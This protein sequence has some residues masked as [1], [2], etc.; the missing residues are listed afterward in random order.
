[1]DGQGPT[2]N[3][4]PNATLGM[5]T[6]LLPFQNPD[7]ALEYYTSKDL[8]DIEAIGYTYGHS[9]MDQ[10]VPDEDATS[11]AV[12]T[13]TATGPAPKIL[14]VAGM[15]RADREGSFMI[16]VF[17]DDQLVGYES[18]LSRGN[19]KGCANCLKTLQV[20]GRFE[21]PEIEEDRSASVRVQIDDRENMQTGEYEFFNGDVVTG[22][23]TTNGFTPD[24][25]LIPEAGG[26]TMKRKAP[27][28]NIMGDE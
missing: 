24:Y 7:N 3:L 16:K 27:S 17:V 5:D 15:S 4:S 6:P 25:E 14:R 1:M 8:I 18:I 26:F 23:L 9:S 22:K 28:V 19:L 10:F 21:L 2:P 12:A 11:V 13:S 20:E